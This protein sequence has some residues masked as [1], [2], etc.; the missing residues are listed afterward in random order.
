[1]HVCLFHRPTPK[2]IGKDLPATITTFDQYYDTLTT[3][4]HIMATDGILRAVILY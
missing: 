4:G 1:M 2:V 3:M